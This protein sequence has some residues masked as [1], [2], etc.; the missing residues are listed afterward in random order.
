VPDSP[1]SLFPSLRCRAT[2]VARLVSGLRHQWPTSAHHG[3]RSPST[4]S[5]WARTARP[6]TDRHL[7]V[8]SAAA[9]LVLWAHTCPGYRPA[10][11]GETRP[12]H[13]SWRRRTCFLASKSRCAGGGTEQPNLSSSPG[14]NLPASSELMAVSAS[15]LRAAGTAWA[16]S[17][18]CSSDLMRHCI[19][20]GSS[21]VRAESRGPTTAH[22]L[23]LAER[24]DTALHNAI[25]SLSC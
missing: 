14:R 6:A 17:V 23:L 8:L 20:E 24:K 13:W 18:T 19:R 25:H 7:S 22:A 16:A 11:C 21:H 1:R 15:E 9:A 12:C 10:G 4:L 5:P 2:T 3:P